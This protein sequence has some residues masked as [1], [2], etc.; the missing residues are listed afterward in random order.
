DP[1]HM[2]ALAEYCRTNLQAFLT[3]ATP[4]YYATGLP[5][6][7]V[8]GLILSLQNGEGQEFLQ[9]NRLSFKNVLPL[10]STLFSMTEG[11]AQAFR[12]NTNLH[13]I[14]NIQ[15]GLSVLF[16]PALHGTVADPDLRGVDPRRHMIV[17]ME[18]NRTAALF[19][20]QQSAE[21]LVQNAAREAGIR[22]P[23]FAQVMALECLT[24]LAKIRTVNVPAPAPGTE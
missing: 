16:Q 10:Q 18:R 8:H 23:E 2:P 15:L 5:D 13:S 22:M 6:A 14:R 3:G 4:N 17:V 21:S 9:G 19:D 1:K 7:N 12:Q 20:P 24:N 11:I